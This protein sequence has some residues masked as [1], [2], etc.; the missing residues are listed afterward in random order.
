MLPLTFLKPI[1]V[2]VS[3]PVWS[4][5]SGSRR[6]KMWP[7]K[8]EEEIHVL[9][10]WMFSVEGWEALSCSFDVLHGGPEARDN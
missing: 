6:A 4:A 7:N 9:N 10:C 8:I 3:D 2:S 5:R 1:S